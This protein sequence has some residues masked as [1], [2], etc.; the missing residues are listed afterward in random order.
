M[1][2]TLLQRVEILREALV[3]RTKKYEARARLEDVTF[4]GGYAEPG[5]TD[6]ESGLIAFGNWNAI[7]EWDEQGQKSRDVDSTPCVFAKALENMGVEIEW[8]DEW[9]TCCECGKAVRTQADSYS[10]QRAYWECEGCIACQS[11]VLSNKPT[12][13][14]YL[15]A[16][17]NQ[18]N[19]CLTFEVPLEKHG[20][21]R[22]DLDCENGWH[23]GQN[24]DPRALA[25]A[26]RERGVTRFI[27][28]LDSVGQ[29]D[30]DFSVW[31]HK[32]EY[33]KV[34]GKE[35]AL[36]AAGKGAD[37]AEVLKRGL[38]AAP[39]VAAGEGI[40]VTKI[41]ADGTA[42]SRRVSPKDFIE[43]KALQD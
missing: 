28:V 29:F 34:A 32:S 10:W 24:D 39:L 6:P 7:R 18:D 16:N 36:Q 4:S 15:E 8:S 20:Y 31:V 35:T 40:V 13:K 33:K 2:K 26:L 27:F 38:K 19:K 11:C 21:E 25:K 12:L 1:S 42:T 22:L 5:Y 30:M 17:E 37:P 23:G 43:G 41:H 14:A 9:T 3:K